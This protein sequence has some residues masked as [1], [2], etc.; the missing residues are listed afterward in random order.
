MIYQGEDWKS[1]PQIA[2]QMFAVFLIIF[3]L[4]QML[5]YLIEAWKIT[6]VEV[7]K[8][9]IDGLIIE[10][11]RRTQL[12]PDEILKLN[13]DK[14]RMSVNHVLKQAGELMAVEINGTNHKDKQTDLI[15]KNFRG[16]NLSGKDLSMT[17]L[18]AANLEGCNLKGTN[19]LGAD[20]RDVNIENVDLSE[21]LFLTQGQINSASGN[22]NT[23]LP[24][25]LCRPMKW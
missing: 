21:S 1:A 3:Q 18:I 23:K 7:L 2:E 17:L 25:T 5:W 13:I 14:Y 22:Q 10:N 6:K 8:V 11:R 16:A 12:S 19:F 15:G 4:N 20:M 9:Q 24:K